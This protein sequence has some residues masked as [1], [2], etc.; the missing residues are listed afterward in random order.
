MDQKRIENSQGDEVE[1][2]E[3]QAE[4][5]YKPRRGHIWRVQDRKFVVVR[6]LD[7]ERVTVRRIE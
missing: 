6:V 5:G 7:R 1:K 2:T 4:G 3:S